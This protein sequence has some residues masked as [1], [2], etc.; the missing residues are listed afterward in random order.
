ML[1]RTGGAQLCQSTKMGLLGLGLLCSHLPRGNWARSGV[2]LGTGEVSGSQAQMVAF[3]S[4]HDHIFEWKH[5]ITISSI[6]VRGLFREENTQACKNTNQQKFGYCVP[7]SLLPEQ[8]RSLHQI[9]R[10]LSY[11]RRCNH[12][13]AL[14]ICPRLHTSSKQHRSLSTDLTP[15][16]RW[17]K[18]LRNAILSTATENQSNTHAGVQEC[19]T[20]SSV[21][22]ASRSNLRS[23]HCSPPHQLTE[24]E[25]K[26]IPYWPRRTCPTRAAPAKL[27]GHMPPADPPPSR[28]VARTRRGRES[29]MTGPR[30]NRHPPPPPI[31]VGQPLPGPAIPATATQMFTVRCNR[32]MGP[33]ENWYH[34]SVTKTEELRNGVR[35]CTDRR[36][37]ARRKHPRGQ[38]GKG[39][40]TGRE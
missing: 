16:P 34:L 21:V 1:A 10:T 6:K 40:Q 5:N 35:L 13:A 18:I 14:R 3:P 19:F 22:A 9:G 24:Q 17:P 20:L 28:A 15:N 31:N 26:A 39:S 4:S 12:G 25:R 7:M 36:G 32:N 11:F 38:F 37:P 23:R 8:I 29:L 33:K 27:R 30:T 2:H